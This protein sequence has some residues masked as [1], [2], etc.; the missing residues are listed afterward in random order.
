VD[1]VFGGM[2]IYVDMWICFAHTYVMALLAADR[3][4]VDP[5]AAVRSGGGGG[6]WLA[7]FPGSRGGGDCHGGHGRTHIP[8]RQ[9]PEM[10]WPF[11]AAGAG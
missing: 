10:L 7:V 11:G 5:P 4:L 8:A 3:Y 6:C 1:V 9:V 2:D